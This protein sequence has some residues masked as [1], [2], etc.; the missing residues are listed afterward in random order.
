MK[1]TR[2]AM[3]WATRTKASTNRMSV[4]NAH[5]M[6]A[7]HAHAFR[8]WAKTRHDLRERLRKAAEYSAPMREMSRG[9]TRCR[10]TPGMMSPASP[11]AGWGTN[12]ALGGGEERQHGRHPVRWARMI[13]PAAF[14]MTRRMLLGLRDRAEALAATRGDRASRAA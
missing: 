5:R 10:R 6:P 2:C 11:A 8:C 13:E 1:P 9:R 12:G 3:P 14:L 7:Q 4:L